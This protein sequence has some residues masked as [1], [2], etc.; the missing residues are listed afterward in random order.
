MK[1]VNSNA[2]ETFVYDPQ[3]IKVYFISDGGYGGD[4]NISFSEKDMEEIFVVHKAGQEVNSG[5]QEGSVVYGS[6]WKTMYFS[7]QGHI[8][9]WL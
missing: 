8:N 3:D 7:S 2:N 9:R 6:R 1:V 4:K 5:F